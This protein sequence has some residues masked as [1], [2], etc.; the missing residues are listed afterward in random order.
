ME[1]GQ[2]AVGT[3]INMCNTFRAV[4]RSLTVSLDFQTQYK[5][6]IIPLTSSQQ[7]MA[8][9]SILNI[10]LH[11]IA[12]GKEVPVLRGANADLPVFPF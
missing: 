5:N 9:W 3:C 12:N 2:G 8:P 4:G 1:Q 7:Q 11:V 6:I 10:L